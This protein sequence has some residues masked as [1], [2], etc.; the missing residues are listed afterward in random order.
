MK[1]QV[2]VISG[3]RAEYGLLKPTLRRII[4]SRLLQLRFLVTGMHTFGVHGMTINE[5][6]KDGIKINAVVRVDTKDDVLGW[7]ACEI[8]GIRNYCKKSR[9][10][11][12][13]VLGDRDESL[14][15]ALVGA[16]LGIPVA[17]IH[18]GDISGN[19]TV[20]ARLRDA[21]TSLS[22]IHFPINRHS[23]DRVK[24]ILG[25]SKQKNIFIVEAFGLEDIRVVTSVNQVYKKH[26]LAAYKPLILLVL[27]PVPLDNIPPQLQI[28]PVLAALGKFEANIIGI[29]PNSDTGSAIIIKQMKL[30]QIFSH[31]YPT[32]PRNDYL[33]LLATCSVLVG[34]S[35]SG[36]L[37]APHFLTPVVNIGKRQ[38][39]RA[40]YSKMI[41]VDYNREEIIQA[42]KYQLDRPKKRIIGQTMKKNPSS[43]IVKY[44]ETYLGYEK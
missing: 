25:K 33:E 35:S 27:H 16:H 29:I 18:G 32:L 30:S 17:H 7:L 31:L 6:R 43:Q 22:S 37:E 1:K 40:S 15:G 42:V 19:V 23:A 44:L 9:P 14:A 38:E 3:T 24:Q 13:L 26:K 36:V 12:I 28:E 11:M 10:D 39:G 5:I 41:T 4:D 34:N 2:L 20:D 8:T 21:I